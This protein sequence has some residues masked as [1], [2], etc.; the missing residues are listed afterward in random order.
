M[1]Q[2]AVLW[3]YQVN[4]LNDWESLE[5]FN[6]HAFKTTI[7]PDD[8]LE[9]S[10]GIIAYFEGLPLALEVFG[11]HLV[12]RPREQWESAFKRLQQIPDNQIQEQL[13]IS[14]D[15]LDRDVKRIFLHI[16][17]FFVGMENDLVRIMLNDCGFYSEIGINVL[18]ESC[19]LKVKGMNNELVMH[20]LVL[21]LGRAIVHEESPQNP[22]MRSLLWFHEDVDY[23]LQNDK[24]TEAIEG[25]SLVLSTPKETKIRST[26]FARINNLRLLK[27]NNVHVTGSLEHLSNQLRW[28]CWHHYPLKYLQSNFQMEKLVV[29]DMRCSKIDTLWEGCKFLKSSKILNL[30]HSNFLKGTMDFNGVPMLETLLLEGCPSL[31]EV[32]SSIG[33]LVRLAHLN[34]K[35]CKELKNLPYSICMLNSLGYLNLIGCSNLDRLP[36]NIGLLKNLTSL[37]IDGCNRS[38]PINYSRFLSIPSCLSLGRS[39]DSTRFLPNSISCLQSLTVLCA[40]NC[41]VS[42][43]DI[44]MEIGILS[45]LTTLDFGK[46]IF[47]F[48]PDCSLNL[49]S[50]L[51][52]LVVDQCESLKSLSELPPNIKAISMDNCVS[53][54]RLPDVSSSKKSILFNL[55]KCSFVAS[56]NMLKS[57]YVKRLRIDPQSNP[58]GIS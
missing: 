24:E 25:I 30:S 32:H 13:K 15:G 18:K 35:G 26:S 54:E 49:L 5:L 20:N 46:N 7:L 21:D 4:K 17:C 45:S 51:E 11:G 9:L 52:Q 36:E 48:L 50:K 2:A 28:L 14:F 3:R 33:V 16:A 57:N 31:L 19:L 55:Q 22:G 38:E 12:R 40:N 1:T 47:C 6:L 43:G 29:L 41:N 8:Y 34:L 42:D 10:K 44:P 27:M 23:V 37:H 39:P 53:I 56:N 58:L